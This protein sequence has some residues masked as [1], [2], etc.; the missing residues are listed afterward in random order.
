MV[1]NTRKQATKPEMSKGTQ[2]SSKPYTE[3]RAP[4]E[5]QPNLMETSLNQA[6][7]E[8]E[9]LTLTQQPADHLQAIGSKQS[10]AMIHSPLDWSG[11]NS[12]NSSD[13]QSIDMQNQFIEPET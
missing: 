12:L 4:Q 5:Y 11:V 10:S 3:L 2:S 8:C 1:R 13:S 7:Y 6:S 9:A